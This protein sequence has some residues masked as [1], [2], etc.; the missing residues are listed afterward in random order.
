MWLTPVGRRCAG[1]TRA[2]TR[3]PGLQLAAL[4]LEHERLVVAEAQDVDD[5][6][7]AVA[8]LA[9]DHA[10]VG[11]LAAAGRVE[12]RLDELD[13]APA[14]LAASSAPTAVACSSRS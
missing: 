4:G 8:V 5:A 14:V 7:A 12:R 2:T 13:A 9:L 6:R 11:D 3:S 1:S 10:G